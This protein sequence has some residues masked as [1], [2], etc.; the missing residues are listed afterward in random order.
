MPSNLLDNSGYLFDVIISKMNLKNDAALGRLLRLNAPAVSK[1][2]NGRMPLG[3]SII[4]RV[5]EE[6]GMSIKEIKSL[7]PAGSEDRV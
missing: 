5:H 1:I 4:I 3:A 6:T 7:M 2:R